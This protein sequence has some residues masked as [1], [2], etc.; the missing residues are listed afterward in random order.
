M[1]PLLDRQGARL[2]ADDSGLAVSGEVD[3]DVAAALAASGSEW[4]SSRPV[5][6]HIHFDLQG[7]NRVSS[8]A[9][10]VMLEWT[11]VARAAGLE[12]SEVE[13]SP[14]LARLTAVAGLDALLPPA[15]AS[16]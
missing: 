16:D 5:G 3:F 9:L 15:A 7:V 12:V 2:E 6:A 11:R 10:S 8:A 14:P 4:L 13:L 1:I